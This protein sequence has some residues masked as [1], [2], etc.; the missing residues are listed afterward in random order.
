L[1]FTV[2]VKF[3]LTTRVRCFYISVIHLS[4]P[5]VGLG[6][7]AGIGLGLHFQTG[8]LFQDQQNIH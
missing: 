3:R 1:T 4:I 5:W 6:L 7:D 8:M 2:S